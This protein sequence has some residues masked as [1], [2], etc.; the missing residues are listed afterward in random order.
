LVQFNTAF[1][2]LIYEMRI[3]LVFPFLALAVLRFRTLWLGLFAVALS[4]CAFPLATLFSSTLHI[5]SPGAALNTT[6]T[7]HYTAFFLIGSIMAKHLSAINR[8]YSRLAPF[9]AA[10]LVFASLCLY[11]FGDASSIVQRFSIPQDLFDW[12]VAAAAVMF[13]VLAIDNRLFRTFLS[14]RAIRYLGERS[15]SLFP[16]PMFKSQTGHWASSFSPSFPSLSLLS[17]AS[18]HRRAP[19]SRCLYLQRPNSPS[20]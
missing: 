14:I 17:S 12:P 18:L 4:L 5:A 16:S 10:T 2:S 20:T 19:Y 7:L 1:W 11:G 6:L 9:K 8:W 13:I 3:S 15:F